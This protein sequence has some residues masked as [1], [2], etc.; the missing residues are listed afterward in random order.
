MTIWKKAIS[1]ATSA[2]LL[3]SLLATAVAPAALGASTSTSGGTII[4]GQDPSAAFSLTFA[5]DAVGQFANGSFTVAV[6]DNKGAANVHFVTTTAP[7]VTRNNPSGT[8]SAGFVAGNLVV[9]VSGVSDLKLESWTISG[10]KVY[11]D[12]GSGATTLAAKGAVIFDVTADTVFLSQILQTASGL[13]TS[14]ITGGVSLTV[15]YSVDAAS[16]LFGVTGATC[17]GGAT[18]GSVTVAAAGVVPAET[19]STSTAAGT[20]TKATPFTGDKAIGTAV[21]QSA[22]SSRFPSAVTVGDAIVLDGGT[23]NILQAGVHSQ[24]P[25]NVVVDLGFYPALLLKGDTV[26]ATIQTAGVTFSTT[27]FNPLCTLSADAKSLACNVAPTADTP[28]DTSFTWNSPIDV[29]AGVPVGTAVNFAFTTSRAGVT[30]I[31]SP[32]TVAYVGNPAAGV[33]VNPTNVII[34]QNNQPAGVLTI[35]ERQAGAITGTLE[36]CLRSSSDA[37][38]AGGRNFWAVRTAGDL[39]FNVGGLPTTQAL[40]L[41]NNATDCLSFNVYDASTA[42]S[43]IQIV[44]GTPTAPILGVGPRL[45]IDLDSIPGPVAVDINKIV[46]T[47]IVIA[48]RVWSGTPIATVSAQLP[49]LRGLLNQAVGS[50]TI[51][52]G[53]PNQFPDGHFDL[54]IVTPTFAVGYS[55]V[56]W[57][58]PTGVNQ[59]VVTTNNAESGLTAFFD[60]FDSDHRCLGLS[61]LDTG[62]DGLGRITVSNVKFDVSGDA[63][64]GAVFVNVRG[65]T[66]VIT[67]SDGEIWINQIVSPAT[68]ITQKT[69]AIAAYSA[70]GL[71]PAAGYTTKTPKYAAIGQY[72]TWKFAGGTVLAGQRVNV[73]VATNSGGVWGPVKYLKSAWADANGTVTF[74]W[75]SSAA[76]WVNVRVQWPGNAAY[77]VSYSKGLAAVVR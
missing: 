40:L 6:L 28:G 76:A 8:A 55:G 61:V 26:T 19:F 77:G 15:T 3:A 17:V 38:W 69:L 10:L 63:P 34:G 21:T 22:C 52:E 31:G 27:G 73:L 33:A 5:E 51:T 59:P 70:L 43:T 54:C 58:T 11:A 36:I 25:A 75:K 45:N 64:L 68:V 66:N 57:S 23:P 53:A 1:A 16:P 29:A 32:V 65:G 35:T 72:V 46:A 18:V 56:R 48:N 47:N 67:E 39:T 37:E 24:F 42:V 2:A 50:I 60:T 4:P 14:A 44:D 71:K 13:T 20:F 49:V 41:V 30:I 7:T 62:K 74:A 12:D 9:T